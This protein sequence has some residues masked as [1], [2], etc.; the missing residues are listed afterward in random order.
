MVNPFALSENYSE[1]TPVG[2]NLTFGPEFGHIRKY[3]T[4]LEEK[5]RGWIKASY[6][7]WYASAQL[8]AKCARG[9]RLFIEPFYSI[10]GSQWSEYDAVN[11][12]KV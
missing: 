3:E 6:H 9:N 12:Y 1:D 8:W 4:V 10:S 5:R 7:G 11:W 2:V